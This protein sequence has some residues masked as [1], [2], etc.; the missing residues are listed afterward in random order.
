MQKVFVT[1]IGLVSALGHGVEANRSAL[2]A[3][4]SGIGQATH[5]DSRLAASLPLGEIPYSN[6]ELRRLVIP[7]DVKTPR[8]RQLLLGI[9]ALRETL[10]GC[11]PGEYPG[12]LGFINATSVAGM[13]EVENIYPELIDPAVQTIDEEYA[14]SL[15]CAQGTEALAR[16]F[17]FRDYIGTISTACSSSA[18]SIMYGIRLIQAGQ[19]DAAVCGGTDT[20]SRFTLNGFNSLK[21]VDHHRCRPFDENRAGLNLGEG[22]AYIMLESEN[23]MKRSGRK[24]LAILSGYCNYNEAFHPTAPSPEGKGAYQAMAGAIQKA[25][26]QPK[27]ISYVNA[28]GTAT[29][30]NDIAEG[31]ALQ[32]LFGNDLPPF[33]STKAFT[34]HTLAAAGAIEAVFS[35]LSLLHEEIYPNLGFENPM[36]GAPIIPETHARQGISLQH[37]LSNSFGFGGNNASLLVSR[38][39]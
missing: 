11:A 19:L 1:G 26:L 2:L 37:I 21:N 25:G 3:G 18:N 27:D 20:L 34:G 16:W 8:N 31:M 36:T 9:P 4:R 33:S 7:K 12:S 10:A 6:E 17:G 13:H 29:E 15:D 35:V 22:A 39:A 38:Y 32:R 30:N 28:H 14:D 24:P 5:L 23:A